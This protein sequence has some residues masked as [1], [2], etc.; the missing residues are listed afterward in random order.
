ME[1]QHP[2]L[3]VQGITGEGRK[4]LGSCQCRRQV[5]FEKSYLVAQTGH[6]LPAMQGTGVDPGSG[7]SPEEGNGYPPSILAW[8]ISW[9]EEPHRACLTFTFFQ[10]AFNSDCTQMKD[11]L[12]PLG[13]QKPQSFHYFREKRQLNWSKDT[14]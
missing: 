11:P 10:L 13:R 1:L 12:L 8:R 4:E 6:N 9:T 5:R 3:T 14:Q 2:L 7:R